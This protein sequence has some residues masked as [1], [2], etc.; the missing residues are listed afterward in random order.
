MSDLN[1]LMADPAVASASGSETWRR[2]ALKTSSLRGRWPAS[3]DR[4]WSV[5]IAALAWDEGHYT[6]TRGVV[7]VLW[8]PGIP[9]KHRVAVDSPIAKGA[10]AAELP[11][12]CHLS[13]EKGA[14]LIG[15]M[16]GGLIAAAASDVQLDLGGETVLLS[17]FIERE[18]GVPYV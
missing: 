1:E 9:T 16:D 15:V 11:S 10:A 5:F 13:D 18:G 14:P 6:G 17:D 4:A 7:A 12:V 8:I 3:E 2:L